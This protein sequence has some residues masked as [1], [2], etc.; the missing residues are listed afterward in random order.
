MD[1]PGFIQLNF[2][3]SMVSILYPTN[4]A[5]T[6]AHAKKE[7]PSFIESTW[8]RSSESHSAS[9]SPGIDCIKDKTLKV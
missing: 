8:V 1:K 4:V 7:F 3:I 6:Y 5:Q 9:K 2:D